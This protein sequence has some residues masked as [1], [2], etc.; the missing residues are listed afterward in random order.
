LRISR[1][2]L[3]T[4]GVAEVVGV[5]LVLEAAPASGGWIHLHAADGIHDAGVRAGVGVVGSV[6]MVFV[7]HVVHATADA[8]PVAALQQAI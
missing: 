7:G 3:A 5:A 8:A 6:V 1:K 4:L 2:A